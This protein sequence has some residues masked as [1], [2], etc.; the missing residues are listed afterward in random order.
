MKEKLNYVYFNKQWKEWRREFARADE[1]KTIA[2]PDFDNCIDD[3]LQFIDDSERQRTKIDLYQK[4]VRK[5]A[6]ELSLF[7]GIDLSDPADAPPDAPADP[8][9]L[10]EAGRTGS[11]RRNPAMGR[12]EGRSTLLRVEE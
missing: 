10:F 11:A 8:P 7:D 3:V 12:R 4:L 9:R 1:F 6:V 5:D 2:D